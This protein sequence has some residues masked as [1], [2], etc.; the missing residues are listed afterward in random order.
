MKKI[1]YLL[2]AMLSLALVANSC[3]EPEPEPT[4]AGDGFKLSEVV[5]AA[6]DFYNT[7]EEERNIP[8]SFTVA[9]KSVTPTQFICAEAQALVNIAAGNKDDIVPVSYAA[10]SNP[11]R[12]SY[13]SDEVDVVAA[14]AKARETLVEI[15]TQFLANAAEKKAVPNQTNIYDGGSDL[16]AFSTNR[17]TV[18]VAR[19][20]AGYAE[21]NSLPASVNT[22]YLPATTSLKAFA[23]QFVHYLEIYENTVADKLSADGSHCT[24]N[25][26]A[27]ERVHFIP[28]PYDT[29]NDYKNEGKDQY[30][31]AKYGNPW[32]FEIEGTTYTAAQS[33]EI[34]IRGLFDLCTSEGASFPL[35]M[36]KDRNKAYTLANGKS[37]LAAPISRPSENCIWGMYP[38]YESA[39]DGGA[40]KYNGEAIS[41]VDIN[42]LL[43]CGGWHIC[44]A[45]YTEGPLGKIGNYQQF[46][47]DPSAALVLDGYEG[48]IAP[49]RE[50]L[51]AARFYKYI[52]DNN[53]TKNVYDAI[54]DV[55]VSFELYD[56]KL[57]VSVDKNSLTFEADEVAPQVIKVTATDPWAVTV[58]GAWLKVTPNKGV[59]GE[60]EVTVI[61]TP[62]TEEAQRTATVTITAGDYSKV[63]SVTQNAYVPPVTGTIMDFAKAFS[64]ILDVWENTV[65]MVDA[66]GHQ[67]AQEPRRHLLR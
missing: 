52:L 47:T 15:A 64:T 28:I 16:V 34:A 11:D 62:Q 31:F 13:T 24:S 8:A 14:K 53:I 18:T 60:T 6:S 20:L 45:F 57:P 61:A 32:Q 23:E 3:K 56:Q 66:E 49:M 46:G 51:I 4:P 5:A 65:G 19:A 39:N 7:W 44:R 22:E 35:N 17:L 29:P 12:D 36:G 25:N 26:N 50:F 59:A 30:D 2:T 41:E 55:K 58:D 48:L 9:G 27:W 21:T 37:L 33:W 67:H 38:W 42:F 63:I 54:K 43:K 1:S 40:V 10:A